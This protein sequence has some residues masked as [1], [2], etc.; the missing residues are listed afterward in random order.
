VPGDA[1]GSEGEG[2]VRIALVESADRLGEAAERIGA[3]LKKQGL[4]EGK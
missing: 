1:F 3:W 2:Y 4:G